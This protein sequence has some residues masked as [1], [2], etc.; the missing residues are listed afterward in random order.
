MRKQQRSLSCIMADRQE[1]QGRKF[2]QEMRFSTH[3][4]TFERL[5]AF[6]EGLRALGHPAAQIQGPC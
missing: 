2:Q 4:H 1:V 6:T 5:A 3:T